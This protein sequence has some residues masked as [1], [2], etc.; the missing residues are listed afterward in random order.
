MNAYIL[1]FN[2]QEFI[3]TTNHVRR[4]ARDYEM[5]AN[6]LGTHFN[7]DIP[8]ELLR[9]KAILVE[10]DRVPCYYAGRSHWDFKEIGG[11]Y[12]GDVVDSA[13]KEN[14]WYNIAV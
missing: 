12:R 10:L 4:V 14:K 2:G 5:M 3:F 8:A 13:Y 6:V 11:T 9:T 7:A 1:T